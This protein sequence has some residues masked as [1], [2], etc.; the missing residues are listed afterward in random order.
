MEKVEKSLEK[1]GIKYGDAIVL[2]ISGGPDSMALLHH[3]IKLREKIDINIICAH[4]NHNLRK[5]SADEKIF[6]EEYCLLNKVVF[7][8]FK[9]E[10]YGDDNFH[11]EARTIRYNYFNSLMEKYNAKFLMTAH[12][13]DDLIETI[14][15]RMVRGSTLKGYGGFAESINMGKYTLA[16]PLIGVTKSEILNYNK[17]NNLSYALDASNEKDVYTRNR[18]RKYVV[19]FLKKEDP[20][21]NDKFLKFSKTLLEYNDFIDKVVSEKLNDI[22]PQ[23]ILNIEKFQKEDKVVQTKIIYYMLEQF[24]QDDLILINDQH[25]TLL[26]SLINSNKANTEIHLPNNIIASKSYNFISLFQAIEKP[27]EYEIEISDFVNLPNAKNI[28]KL[29][30]AK[31]NNNNYCRLSSSEVK[32][33]LFVRNKKDGDKM[34]IKGMLGSR[35]ISDIFIDSKI[36]LSDRNLWPVVVD[37]DNNIVWLPGLK[38]SKFDK[39][40][41]EK[42]DIILRYY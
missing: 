10:N 14:L 3:V 39:Q 25:V 21:V 35:K 22:Y 20:H 41:D 15:M 6:V 18:F 9:I 24:Y 31:E 36:K 11:N 16:R 4:V 17:E 27:G 12:H 40:K 32:L 26:T 28:E 2:G 38:K 5:E 29:T 42:C 13:G 19:S 7:E 37:S 30:T 8:Y 23:K 34:Q 33:P 1:L